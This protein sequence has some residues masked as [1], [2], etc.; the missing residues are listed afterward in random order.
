MRAAV[1]WIRRAATGAGARRAVPATATAILAAALASILTPGC[2][3]PYREPNPSFA[4]PH[5]EAASDLRRMAE[6]PVQLD[7]P[8][9]VLAGIGDPAVSSAAIIAALRPCLAGPLVEVDFFDEHTFEG[10]R[11]KLLTAVA[12]AMFVDVDHLPAVDVVAFSMGGLVAR[13]AAILDDA[14]R[15]LPIHRLFTI[16]TP[17]EGARLAGIPLGTPQSEDMKQTSDFMHRLRSARREYELVC[18]TRLDDI[19]VGEEFAVPEGADLWW[20]PTPSGEW[21][22]MHAFEDE[23]IMADLARRLRGEAPFSTLPAAPLPN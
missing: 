14:G 15:R 11:Q 6:S 17:H 21:A 12:A 7:R 20:L 10:A 13:D 22:H 1:P 2:A 4:V 8:V 3:L 23:R 19:T 18:Y 9:I 5:A 16:S